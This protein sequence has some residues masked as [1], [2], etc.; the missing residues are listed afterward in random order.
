MTFPKLRLLFPVLAVAALAGWWLTPHY[1]QQ[2][3][4][5]YVAVFC[6]ISHDNRSRFL[7]DMQKVIEGGNSD[8]AL[9]KVV[10]IPALGKK[11]VARWM[12]LTPAAQQRAG[13][14]DATC[15]QLLSAQQQA[16]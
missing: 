2:D 5:Y 14:N 13:D 9:K 10:F 16:K 4:S 1:S 7:D 11:V 15:Q 8:Y 6:S 3:E 12:Q